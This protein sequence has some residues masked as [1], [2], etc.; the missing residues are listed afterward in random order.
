MVTGVDRFRAHFKG[1]DSQY[2]LIGGAACELLMDEVGLDFRATKD[3]DIVLIVEALD[4][5]FSDRFWAFVEEGGYEIRQQSEGKRVLY[6]FQKPANKEFPAMLELFS[7][8]PEG[9]S[10]ADDS[11]LTPLPI[12]EEAASLSAI[13]LDS[14]YYEFLKSMVRT[15]DGIPVL[16]GAA[17]I[18]FKARAWLDLSRRREEGE[19][20]D[21]KDVRKHRNDVARMLQLLATDASYSLPSTVQEDMGAFVRAVEVQEDFDPRQ[22]DVNM[23]RDVVVERLRAA[24]RL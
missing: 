15:L 20:I 2:V 1:H 12:D 22:F 7:R 18:P 5:A 11:H 14:A 13:L 6:R 4:A 8:Q 16:N 17:I 9:I 3:L 19:K 10:L 21:E 24:Y 23:T